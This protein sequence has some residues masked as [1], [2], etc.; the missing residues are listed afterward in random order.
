MRTTCPR[1]G[2][3]YAVGMAVCQYCGTPNEEFMTV[4]KGKPVNVSF[5]DGDVEH[6]V[7]FLISGIEATVET[8]ELYA[9]GS[10]Y[11]QVTT[12]G[13]ELTITGRIVPMEV[14]APDGTNRKVLHIWRKGGTG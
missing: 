12:P 11:R 10:L 5:K 2:G 8:C 14:D 9:D 6:T 13:G 1:C 3:A 4:V 7:S